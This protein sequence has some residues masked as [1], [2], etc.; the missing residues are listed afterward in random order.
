[1]DGAAAQGCWVARGARLCAPLPSQGVHAAPSLDTNLCCTYKTTA[2][3]LSIFDPKENYIWSQAVLHVDRRHLD[4]EAAK[5][6]HEDLK[7]RA[8]MP[9]P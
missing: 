2:V 9:M 3:S 4:R 5:Q 8:P 7:V 6:T 1:M